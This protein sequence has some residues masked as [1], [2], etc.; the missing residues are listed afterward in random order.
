MGGDNPT[1]DQNVTEGLL[2]SMG[3]ASVDG[4]P[5]AT[6]RNFGARDE[7]RWELIPIPPKTIKIP[8]TKTKFK[9]SFG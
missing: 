3:I 5:V 9:L 6:V 7:R 2:Q 4:R 1:P 8:K